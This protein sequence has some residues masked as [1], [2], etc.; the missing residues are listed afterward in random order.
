MLRGRRI[1]VGTRDMLRP[2]PAGIA[3]YGQMVVRDLAAAGAEVSALCDCPRAGSPSVQEALLYRDTVQA[4]RARLARARQL[5]SARLRRVEAREFRPQGSVL[6]PPSEQAW[7]QS[8]DTVEVVPDCYSLSFRLMQHF[9]RPLRIRTRRPVDVW[10]AIKPLAIQVE[11]A[12]S[13]AT[14]HDMVPLLLPYTSGTDPREFRARLGFASRFAD[15]IIAVSRRTK[16][17]MVR[18]SGI[19]AERIHVVYP[20]VG[21]PQR[22]LA[23]ERVAAR[24][25]PLGLVPDG[26]VLFC[27]TIEPRKNL[28]SLME[29]VAS[30]PQAPPLV[31]CGQEGWLAEEALRTMSV[32]ERQGRVVRLGYVSDERLG[33]LYSG[34]VLLAY[35]SLYEGF[36]FPAVEA[37]AHGCPVLTSDAGALP[38]VCGDAAL[39][40]DPRDVEDITAKL[41]RLLDDA[42]LRRTLAQ[43]GLRRARDFSSENHVRGLE[44]VYAGVLK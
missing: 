3:R 40:V 36:G 44:E 34:A 28:L 4:S 23:A 31:V 30:L 7:R 6:P 27:G 12:R 15:A 29:A 25:R 18:L 39:Y 26:Y 37:M 19:A 24:L 32:L 2:K 16:E 10:H 14:V 41:Q 35:P 17:D 33:A 5:L 42:E 21:L 13:V 38:E 9:G 43:R 1:L 11:G 22:P 8:V 20:P